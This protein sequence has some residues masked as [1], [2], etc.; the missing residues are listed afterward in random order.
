M[1]T[2][3]RGIGRKRVN[4][5][6]HKLW[7]NCMRRKLE[8]CLCAYVFNL[9]AFVGL[10]YQLA[11]PLHWPQLPCPSVSEAASCSAGRPFSGCEPATCLELKR[12][13]ERAASASLSLSLSSP[14]LPSETVS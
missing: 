8:T 9:M 11:R 2:G 1:C 14:R 12:A 13:S 6:L 7:L 3:I 10:Q 4:V 5:W